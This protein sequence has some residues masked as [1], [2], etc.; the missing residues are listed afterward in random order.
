MYELEYLPSALDDLLEAVRYIGAEL[1]NPI[2]A[3]RFAEKV[4]AAGERLQEFP[5]AHPVYIPIRPME[6]EYRKML[7]QNHFVFYRVSEEKKL[8]TVVRVVYAKREN[9]L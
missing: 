8:V 6:H 1:A 9:F 2:A 3:T 4:A 7:V 5:Y